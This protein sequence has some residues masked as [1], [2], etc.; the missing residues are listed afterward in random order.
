MFNKLVRTIRKQIRF[1]FQE[2]VDYFPLAPLI[3]YL[4]VL[5]LLFLYRLYAWA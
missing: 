4:A 5:F 1:S 2:E 3:I